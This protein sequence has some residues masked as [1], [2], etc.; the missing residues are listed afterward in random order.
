VFVGDALEERIGIQLGCQEGWGEGTE[1]MKG[2]VGGEEMRGRRERE[3]KER[4][5]KGEGRRRGEGRIPNKL[6]K[7]PSFE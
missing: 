6:G 4:K 2:G 3:T 5:Q 7:G 1:S